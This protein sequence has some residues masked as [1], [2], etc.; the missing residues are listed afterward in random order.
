MDE[1]G[2]GDGNGGLGGGCGSLGDVGWYCLPLL[3]VPVS[4]TL[5][6]EATRATSIDLLAYLAPSGFP[7]TQ[8]GLR[9]HSTVIKSTKLFPVVAKTEG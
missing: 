9:V 3:S 1:G 2:D 7:R 5:E 4:F 8:C 6:S